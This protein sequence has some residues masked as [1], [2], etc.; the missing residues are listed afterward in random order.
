MGFSLLNYT[1]SSLFVILYALWLG[2]SFHEWR[3]IARRK[4]FKIV[5]QRRE[6]VCMLH[7]RQRTLHLMT[8]LFTFSKERLTLGT[9]LQNV[10]RVQQDM[11][12]Q[13]KVQLLP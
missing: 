5:F 1:S 3:A 4:G 7:I 2:R 12:F 11:I 9:L 6:F 10:S 13:L 8:S